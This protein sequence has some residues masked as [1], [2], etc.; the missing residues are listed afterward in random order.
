MSV[1]ITLVIDDTG[2]AESTQATGA[3]A[4]IAAPQSFAEA[5][6]APPTIVGGL[7]GVSEAGLSGFAE[8]RPPLELAELGLGADFSPGSE[9]GQAPSEELVV[10]DESDTGEASEQ[11]MP[12][13]ELG[14]ASEPSAR[15]PARG[16]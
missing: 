9:G 5:D 3:P 7:E 4:V 16:K 6:A 14:E 2:T 13:E 8:D 11:P 12:I 1:T 15:R 10:S